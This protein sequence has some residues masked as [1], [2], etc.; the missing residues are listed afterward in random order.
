MADL[1][2]IDALEAIGA[3]INMIASL[4]MLAQDEL[5]AGP[6]K[7]GMNALEAAS[8]L[9]VALDKDVIALVDTHYAPALEGR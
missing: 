6:S 7:H 4:L 8:R 2:P 3:D 1:S 5:T 9:M